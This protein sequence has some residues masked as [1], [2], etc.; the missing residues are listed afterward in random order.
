MIQI[1]ELGQ[2]TAWMGRVGPGR[3]SQ[4]D[5]PVPVGQLREEVKRESE[6]TRLI[7]W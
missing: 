7:P 3:K 1:G 4:P 5:C 2:E 6:R